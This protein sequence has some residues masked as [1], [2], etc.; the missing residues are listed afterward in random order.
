M[1]FEYE[2]KTYAVGARVRSKDPKGNALYG[3][4]CYGEYDDNEQY[5]DWVH[6][7]FYILWDGPRQDKTTFPDAL[8]RGMEVIE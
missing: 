8:V 5:S 3:A 4:I 2:G 7:G 6:L 1:T